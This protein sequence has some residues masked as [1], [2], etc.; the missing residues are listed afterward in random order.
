ML[1]FWFGCPDFLIQRKAAEL[2]VYALTDQ[3]S[4]RA[5]KERVWRKPSSSILRGYARVDQTET[6]QPFSPNGNLTK[7]SNLEW[8][9]F[10]PSVTIKYTIIYIKYAYTVISHTHLWA[11]EDNYKWKKVSSFQLTSFLLTPTSVLY[12]SEHYAS[13]S[14]RNK[15]D[16]SERHWPI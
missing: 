3:D 8:S 5:W 9:F 13:W 12:C 7:S 16:T 14:N 6:G 10:P 15:G 4:V 11:D 2:D 1:I